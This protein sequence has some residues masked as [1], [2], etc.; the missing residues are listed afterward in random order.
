MQPLRELVDGLLAA[1]ITPPAWAI[2]F[3]IEDEHRPVDP[4]LHSQPVASVDVY[5]RDDTAI[6]SQ[7]ADRDAKRRGVWRRSSRRSTRLLFLCAL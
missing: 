4:N 1:S 6:E 7:L 2:P 5:V 3:L